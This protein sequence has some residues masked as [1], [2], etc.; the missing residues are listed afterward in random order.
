M[1]SGHGKKILTAWAFQKQQ[2]FL[3]ESDICLPLAALGISDTHFWGE[4][5]CIK[6]CLKMFAYLVKYFNFSF[7]GKSESLSN[8]HVDSREGGKKCI[9]VLLKTIWNRS[10]T[11]QMSVFEVHE[12]GTGSWRA[13][14]KSERD[15]ALQSCTWWCF[16]SSHGPKGICEP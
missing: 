13:K 10:H 15:T 7:C 9:F 12:Q 5:R 4:N 2:K 1:E 8:R 11:L 6:T 16:W 3:W 14:F